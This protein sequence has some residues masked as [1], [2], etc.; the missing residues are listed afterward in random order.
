MLEP[1]Y[2]I[3]QPRSE[4]R[5]GRSFNPDE[6]AIA[7]EQVVAGKA[8]KDYQEPAQFFARTCF[9]RALRDHSAKVLRRLAG[10]TENAPPV[11]T[12]I[13]QFGGG[14]THTLTALYHIANGGKRASSWTGV[15]QVLDAAGLAEAPK[16]K[17]AVFVGNAWDPQPGRE[18][19]WIDVAR[20]LAG[21]KGVAALGGDA[22]TAPPGTD[23]INRVIDLAGGTVLLLFDEVLNGLARHKNLAEPMHAFLHN[24][25]RGFI[26]QPGRAAVVSLPRSQVEM[27]PFDQTWQEKFTKLV[28]AVAQQLVANDE[29]EISEVVRRRLFEDIGKDTVRRNVAKAFADWCFERRA[30]L[31][32]EWTAADTA[33][34]EAG[35]RDRLRQRFDACYPF[36]PA[37]LTVF[38]RKW[39]SLPQFQQTRG[40]L[41]MLAQWIS[42][43]Y[44]DGYQRARNEPLITLGSAPL[45]VPD[46]R[47]TVLG[48]LGEQRLQAAL[49]TDLA[50]QASHART[51]DADTKGPLKDIHRRVGAAVFF[52]SSGGQSDKVAYLP[53]VRFAVGEP[54]LDTTTIDNAVAALQRR[55]YYL[56]KAGAD[57]YRFFSTPTLNKVVADRRASLDPDDVAKAVQ[58]L[59]EEEFERRKVLAVEHFRGESAE[60]ADVT[61]LTAVVLPS[62][63]EWTEGGDLRAQI[64][65]WTVKRGKEDRSHPGALLWMARK[66]GRDLPDKTGAW[67][68]WRRVDRDLRD[69]ILGS[70]IEKAERQEVAAQVKAAEEDARDEVWASYRFLVL[71][72]RSQSD[73]L[74][75]LD[76][77]AGHASNSASLTG[78]IVD[79]L[80]SRTLLNESPGAGYLERRWPPALKESG[81]W[82]VKGLRQAF[83]SGAME[84]ILDVDA[85]LK[86][87]IPEFVRRGDFGFASGSRADGRYDRVWFEEELPADEVTFDAGVFLLTKARA[88]QLRKSAAETVITPPQE[89]ERPREAED[90]TRADEPTLEVSAAPVTIRVAGEVPPESWNRLGTR[91]IPK[92][93]TGNQLAVRIEI[94]VEVDGAQAEALEKELKRA[95]EDLGLGARITVRR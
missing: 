31:P 84:R 21:D 89:P 12:L 25:M 59:I 46:L 73:G 61:R 34:S 76:I 6:F 62:A 49:D 7:L 66:P 88:R 54:G 63:Y 36:H 29:S 56:R 40:T 51:L 8:P 39:Q 11:L 67:L 95:I 53:D 18:T 35:V 48:Q 86:S 17:V 47:G 60:L 77:G 26:G 74:E 20:Q 24:I 33:V 43:A 90:S 92:L 3:A 64:A 72:D 1:W 83:L 16:T 79:E 37:T 28:G 69:G 91:L 27:T 78:R 58:K 85:Y 9:T 57:G 4:V 5:E 14:K 70:E 32:P 71:A 75:V 41:A 38:Q 19:P 13:T 22:R 23:A 52:E 93:R 50:G 94:S 15:R 45:E 55:A 10:R 44:R 2:K 87:K 42:W 81:A 82:P 30:Q 68:A 80:R 65:E